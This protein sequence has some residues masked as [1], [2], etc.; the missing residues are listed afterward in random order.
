MRKTVLALTSFIALTCAY[1]QSPAPSPAI[2]AEYPAA[3]QAVE[4][5]ELA[6]QLC[7]K[8]ISFTA[9]SGAKI[10]VQ[11]KG[12]GYFYYDDSNGGRATGTWAMRDA[13]LCTVAR[14]DRQEVCSGIRRHQEKWLLKRS[15]NGEIVELNVSD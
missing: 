6:K 12:N 1:A 7:G 3:A 9:R 11:L 13:G 2:V 14:G 15:S 5:E 10:K 4:A 8:T